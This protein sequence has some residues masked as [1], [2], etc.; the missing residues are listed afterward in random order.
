[1]K[2]LRSES[3]DLYKGGWGTFSIA[4]EN[5]SFQEMQSKVNELEERKQQYEVYKAGLKKKRSK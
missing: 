5:P 3:S 1:V 4:F 2:K